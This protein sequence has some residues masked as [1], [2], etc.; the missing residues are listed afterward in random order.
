MNEGIEMA[1]VSVRPENES[2]DEWFER[3][4]YALWSRVPRNPLQLRCACEPK[5][6]TAFAQGRSQN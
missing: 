6:K 2:R 4:V 1:P 5:A 3:K